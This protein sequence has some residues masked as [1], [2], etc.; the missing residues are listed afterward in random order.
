[1]QKMICRL[2][3]LID[4]KNL[5]ISESGSRGDRLSQ[6]KIAERT[7]IAPT[8]LNRLYKNEF[9]RIDTNTIEK[10]CD[11]F[12]CNIEDLFVLKN[13]EGWPFRSHVQPSP[14]AAQSHSDH[15]HAVV[16]LQIRKIT[17]VIPI[18]TNENR[19]KSLP[20]SATC[21]KKYLYSYL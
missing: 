11:F 3:S 9:S 17:D 7:G 20:Q 5:E 6:R 13:I 8:T 19:S 10:L 16:R 14:K 15:H 18:A 12:S 2:A 4:E 1:M 21:C